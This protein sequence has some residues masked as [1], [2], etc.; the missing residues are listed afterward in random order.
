MKR[1]GETLSAYFY[2][3][4]DNMKRVYTMWLQPYHV[5][6]KDQT[7]AIVNNQWLPEAGGVG[8]GAWRKRWIL[9]RVQGTFK[10]VKL[11]CIIL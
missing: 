9:S 6:K 3:K 4:E 2:M 7:M 5:L 1:H 11:F 10:A 8:M